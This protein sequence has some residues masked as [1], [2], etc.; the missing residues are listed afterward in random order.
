M[1]DEL[2]LRHLAAQD[3]DRRDGLDPPL[4]GQADHGGL[5][6]RLVGVQGVLDLA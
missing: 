4:V 1:R 2:I 5:G 3:D 6:D